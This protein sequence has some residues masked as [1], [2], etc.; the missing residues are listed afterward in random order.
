MK[1]THRVVGDGYIWK[2]ISLMNA[3]SQSVSVIWG[4]ECSQGWCVIMFHSALKKDTEKVVLL[5]VKGFIQII[6]KFRAEKIL[7]SFLSP[8]ILLTSMRWNIVTKTFVLIWNWKAHFIQ[9]HNLVQ[10]F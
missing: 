5:E 9:L 10:D 4:S 7:C 2:E 6:A 8:N 1:I 3:A